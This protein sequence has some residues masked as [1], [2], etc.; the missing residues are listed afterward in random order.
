M[1]M[2]Q[3]RAELLLVDSDLM[4]LVGRGSQENLN[5]PELSHFILALGYFYKEDGRGSLSSTG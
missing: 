5:F 1:T 4:D 2:G 3:S